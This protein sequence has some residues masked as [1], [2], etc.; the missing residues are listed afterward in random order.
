MITHCDR[1]NTVAEGVDDPAA[2]VAGDDR[3]CSEGSLSARDHIGVA[4]SRTHDPDPYLAGSG[5]S[6]VDLFQDVRRV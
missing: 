1:G 5:F 4:H 2:F 6:Q 3:W